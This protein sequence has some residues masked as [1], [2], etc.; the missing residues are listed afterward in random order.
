MEDETHPDL[1]LTLNLGYDS[2]SS[3]KCPKSKLES[4]NWYLERVKKKKIRGNEASALFTVESC[5]F[6]DDSSH[7]KDENTSSSSNFEDEILEQD[8]KVITAEEN[9]E[10]SEEVII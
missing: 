9:T 5:Y 8:G 3:I 1:V 10:K 7:L 2:L 4:H 6:T